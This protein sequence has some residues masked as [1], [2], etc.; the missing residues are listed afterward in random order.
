MATAGWVDKD[1]QKE[2]QLAAYEAKRE[3]EISSSSSGGG[4]HGGDCSSELEKRKKLAGTQVKAQQAAYAAKQMQ[5]KAHKAAFAEKQEPGR[6]AHPGQEKERA[7]DLNEF[8]VVD[9]DD[10]EI[11]KSKKAVEHTQWR[12]R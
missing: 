4:C 10:D 12:T 8:V 3:P 5:A 6:R 11:S 7:I 1:L 9:D 2:A